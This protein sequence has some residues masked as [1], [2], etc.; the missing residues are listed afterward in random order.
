MRAIPGTDG[1]D[2]NRPGQLL[3]FAHDVRFPHLVRNGLA[4]TTSRFGQGRGPA[5]ALDSAT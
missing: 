3:D 4:Q 5:A 2:W 1:V